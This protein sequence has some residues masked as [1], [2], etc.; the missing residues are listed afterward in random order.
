MSENTP[1]PTP[2]PTPEKSVE[3]KHEGNQDDILGRLEAV[4]EKLVHHAE[5]ANPVT[6]EQATDDE[7]PVRPPW[8]HRV[9]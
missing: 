1:D 2:D 8:T 3:E 7:P 4:V 9:L 5:A 6:P